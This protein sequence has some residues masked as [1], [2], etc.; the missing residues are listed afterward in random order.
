MTA[1]KVDEAAKQV[2]F[3]PLRRGERQGEY[4]IRKGSM[5]IVLG[6]EGDRLLT[7]QERKAYGLEGLK[8]FPREN[9]CSHEMT[10]FATLKIRAPAALA[11]AA[12]WL[13]G[14]RELDLPP[15][16]RSS[17]EVRRSVGSVPSGR[18]ELKIQ[19]GGFQPVVRRFETSVD[20]EDAEVVVARQ[21]LQK[22]N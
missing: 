16:E 2:G 3:P 6:F 17:S 22:G 21:E 8:L 9:L 5:I 7:F 19:K 4:F 11:G 18:H 15:A 10:G 20:Q 14:N 13:D 1:T 12:I